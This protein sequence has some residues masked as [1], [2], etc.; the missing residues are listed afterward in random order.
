MPNPEH[1]DYG[2][3]DFMSGIDVIVM[4]RNTFEKVLTFS[5]WP[6][7]KPVFVLSNTLKTVPEDIANKI[8]IVN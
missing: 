3:T 1:S 6:Y 8:E 5:S 4:G 2:F 7:R